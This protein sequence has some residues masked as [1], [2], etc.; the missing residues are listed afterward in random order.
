MW[1]LKFYSHRSREYS[2]KQRL[3]Q[4]GG[5]RDWER[6]VKKYKLIVR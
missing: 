6:L 2:G 5:M 1:N 3:G 4:L